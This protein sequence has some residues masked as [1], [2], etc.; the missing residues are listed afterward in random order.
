MLTDDDIKKVYQDIVDSWDLRAML[1]DF[2]ERQYYD[3]L[4][5]KLDFT[6]YLKRR[7]LIVRPPSS[8]A[9]RE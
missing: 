7:S 6:E 5:H 8:L 3:D 1:M 2:F 4:F 9:L